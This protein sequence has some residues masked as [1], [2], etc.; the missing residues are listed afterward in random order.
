MIEETKFEWLIQDLELHFGP[1]HYNKDSRFKKFAHYYQHLGG[2]PEE[3]LRKAIDNVIGNYSSDKKFGFPPIEY[4]KST[5]FQITGRDDDIR[6]DPITCGKCDGRGA[7]VDKN[8]ILTPCTCEAGERWAA[9]L[10]NFKR[11]M[12]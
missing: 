5:I 12:K 6:E 1:L 8:N 10:K 7:T 4:I 3:I 2:F 9:R 11:R